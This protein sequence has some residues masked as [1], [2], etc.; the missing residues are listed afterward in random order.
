M[1]ELPE[2]EVMR[3]VLSET[4]VGKTIV[5]AR[6]IHPGI[7]KTVEPAI[8]DLI[9]HSVRAISRRSKHLIFTVDDTLHVVL[10][11]MLA[12]RL[13]LCQ[14]DTKA[15]KATGFVLSL[16][17]GDDLRV[18]EN[19]TTHLVRVHVVRDPREVAAIAK[20]GAEPLSEAFTLEYLSEHVRGRRRQLKKTLTD[21]TVIAGIGSAYADEILF[22]AKLS[23]IRYGT[24]LTEEEVT[25]LHRSIRSVLHWAIDEIRAEAGGAAL[26]PHG[27]SFTR[28]YKKTNQPCPECGTR[29]A[30]IRY[31]QTK[32]YYCP[33]CQS[34]DKTI[35]DRR[36]WLTR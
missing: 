34:S 32:T 7:L 23:P 10:H 17:D 20:A 12:G 31:A 27:R 9:G 30:E 33:H 18:I 35:K 3:D 36:A 25:R 14:S 16:A 19:S 29:I 1:P 24:T 15:T 22:D 6:S 4:L 8:D 5:A 26:T 28:I 2:L 21:Q 13:I 11:L